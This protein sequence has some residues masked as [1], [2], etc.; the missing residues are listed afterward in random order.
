[1]NYLEKSTITQAFLFQKDSELRLICLGESGTLTIRGVV[2]E[3]RG[4]ND[5]IS[6]V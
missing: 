5:S 4:S 3:L 1:M 6:L 2:V